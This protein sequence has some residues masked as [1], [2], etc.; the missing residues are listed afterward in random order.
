MNAA[1]DLY[2]GSRPRLGDQLRLLFELNRRL[3]NFGDLDDL[4]RYATARTRELFDAEGCAVLLVEPHRHEFSFA[5]ASESATCRASSAGLAAIRFPTTCG[6]A[7]WVFTHDQAQLVEDVARDPRFYDGV[8]QQTEVRTRSLLCVPLRTAN[9]NIGVLEVVN[10]A[11]GASPEDLEFL[12][13]LAADVAVAYDTARIQDRAPALGPSA[14]EVCGLAG[15][16]FVALGILAAI[17]TTVGHLAWAL[18][19]RELPA[20]PGLL[21][22]LGLLLPG[23]ALASLAA[24]GR[25]VI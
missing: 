9:G 8:D 24:R 5:A 4:L 6:I 25:R 15:I 14:R 3:A 21:T 17:G 2:S 16:T 11:P 18:P 22:A 7:G 13:A 19:L 12:E 10:P 23:V 20:R 1:V